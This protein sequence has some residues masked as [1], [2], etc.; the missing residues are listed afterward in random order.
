MTVDAVLEAT[1]RLLVRD[2]FESMNV[3]EVADVA[4]VSIGSVYQYYATK[5][6]LLN[7]LLEEYE[8]QLLTGLTDALVGDPGGAPCEVV[9]RYWVEL[10][11]ERRELHRV[12]LPL[13]AQ[14]SQRKLVDTRAE[15]REV[16]AA[17]LASR[18]EMG[19]DEATAGALGDL[20]LALLR[21]YARSG[22][23]EALRFDVAGAR[24]LLETAR[25]FVAPRSVPGEPSET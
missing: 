8:E 22:L 21:A 9:A 24:A 14:I 2:G 3:N 11:E 17:Y 6:S 23:V 1:R 4:G 15:T 5:E 7:A 12:L 13:D 18:P 19:L 10:H 20:W 25:S 16:L